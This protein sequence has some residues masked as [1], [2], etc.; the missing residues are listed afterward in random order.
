MEVST[1]SFEACLHSIRMY[2][3]ASYSLATRAPP[4]KLKVV[5]AE[6]FLSERTYMIRNFRCG[7]YGKTGCDST[8]VTRRKG[9]G[10]LN[11]DTC[12]CSPVIFVSVIRIEK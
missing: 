10:A 11:Q 4:T 9:S 8:R 2:R 7:L 6:T 1:G 3:T 5:E 12:C